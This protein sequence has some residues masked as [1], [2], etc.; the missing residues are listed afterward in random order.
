MADR[1]EDPPF[2]VI[3][4]HPER[5][6]GARLSQVRSIMT[7]RY[8]RRHQRPKKSPKGN[9]VRF[10]VGST[11]SVSLISNSIPREVG[12]YL[13]PSR[14]F[15]HQPFF[16]RIQ[17]FVYQH[18]H[19]YNPFFHLV[20]P[21]S[22]THVPLMS[23]KI[24]N[25]SAWDD[26]SRAGRISDITF[27]QRNITLKLLNDSLSN[28]DEASSDA[29]IG[30]MIS[31]NSFNFI[32][33]DQ[34][35]FEHHQRGIK[36]LVQ[37]RGGPDELG[38][39]GHLKNCLSIFEELPRILRCMPNSK[40]PSLDIPLPSIPADFSMFTFQNQ[41]ENNL[42]GIISS[43]LIELLSKFYQIVVLS[44]DLSEAHMLER[45]TT[46]WESVAIYNYSTTTVDNVRSQ[47]LVCAIFLFSHPSI[48]SNDGIFTN[49]SW[50]IPHFQMLL[51]QTDVDMN[52]GPLPGA[53]I[54]CLLVGARRSPPG[55][56]RKWFL[57]QIVRLIVP[58]ALDRTEV[59]LRNFRLILAGL[60]AMDLLQVDAR[61]SKFTILPQI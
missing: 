60:D 45:W 29:N 35:A 26:L 7:K 40:L 59:M 12:F 30:A 23:V 6:H 39:N 9:G 24:L 27:H 19:D 2:V 52:W 41:K 44:A 46:M 16:M 61:N 21:A 58:L 25:A 42:K 22:I 33:D 34:P 57:M 43:D 5:G 20:L 54:W 1:V 13:D 50:L 10:S 28:P 3:T 53:L 47:A 49:R 18:L 14:Y 11:K 51:Q 15:W 8:H 38:F 37:L 48:T 56:A 36:R 55:L 32:N 4:G 17:K 31:Y